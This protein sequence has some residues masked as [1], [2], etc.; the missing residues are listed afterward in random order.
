MVTNKM[1]VY[2]N[3]VLFFKNITILNIVIAS[4]NFDLEY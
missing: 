4:L 3:C 2:Y 1:I